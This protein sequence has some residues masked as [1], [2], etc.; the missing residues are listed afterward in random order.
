VHPLVDVC[1]TASLAFAIPVSAF[2]ID[3]VP[4]DFEVRYA[5]GDEKYQPFSGSG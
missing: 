3:T 2:D 4:G 1:C 5:D